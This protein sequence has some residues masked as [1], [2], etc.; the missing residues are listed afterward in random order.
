MYSM[1]SH[2]LGPLLPLEPRPKNTCNALHRDCCPHTAVSS[3]PRRSLKVVLDNEMW[4]S[5]L[6][7]CLT[8]RPLHFKW[9]YIPTNPH[10]WNKN[11]C[12]LVWVFIYC[13]KM[14]QHILW[15]CP[16]GTWSLRTRWKNITL[17]WLFSMT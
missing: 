5:Y 3:F 7:S 12:V 8:T 14:K 15:L 17:K 16:E 9:D 4:E 13:G 6:K 11:M 1:W 2:G 10:M